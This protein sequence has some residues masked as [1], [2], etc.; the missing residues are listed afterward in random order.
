MTDQEKK[1]KEIKKDLSIFIKDQEE[2]IEGLTRLVKSA[3]K[4]Q[5]NLFAAIYG[6][7]IDDIRAPLCK[8]KD[9]FNKL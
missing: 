6:F 2:K 5:D 1:I 9:V 7:R 8:I 4:H 3:Y